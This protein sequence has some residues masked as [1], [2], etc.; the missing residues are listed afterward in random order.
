MPV[1]NG[2]GGQGWKSL[3]TNHHHHRQSDRRWLPSRAA[4][5]AP[6]TKS[7]L[8]GLTMTKLTKRASNIDTVYLLEAR[9]YFRSWSGVVQLALLEAGPKSAIAIDISTYSGG[10]RRRPGFELSTDKIECV[11]LPD[12]S[13]KNREQN[14]RKCSC[15]VGPREPSALV[16]GSGTPQPYALPSVEGGTVLP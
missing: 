14:R 4:K 9:L 2:R 16:C 15:S 5:N 7:L 10:P 13:K 8:A 3:S 6:R 11:R 12:A 1:S